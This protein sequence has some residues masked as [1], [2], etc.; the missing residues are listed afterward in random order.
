MYS[1]IGQN[2]AST[3]SRAV[4]KTLCRLLPRSSDATQ[5]MGDA[6]N[7][8]SDEC[9]QRLAGSRQAKL[10]PI[11]VCTIVIIIPCIILF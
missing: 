11:N 10:G 9:R 8:E 5:K 3:Q 1:V 4:R 2:V 7:V 6:K